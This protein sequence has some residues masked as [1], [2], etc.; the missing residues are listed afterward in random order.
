M[1]GALPAHQQ[2]GASLG[3][4]PHTPMGHPRLQTL[5]AVE[6]VAL[7]PDLADNHHMR[8]DLGAMSG[9]LLFHCWASRLLTTVSE[10]DTAQVIVL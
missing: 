3:T 2:V 10:M 7:E 1:P 9:S 6:P 5:W 8:Q 4:Q